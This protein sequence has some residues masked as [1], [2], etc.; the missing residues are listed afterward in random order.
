VRMHT[1]IR[2]RAENKLPPKDGRSQV[3]QKNLRKSAAK[4]PFL[5]G[6]RGSKSD[7]PLESNAFTSEGFPGSKSPFAKTEQCVRVEKGNINK[8]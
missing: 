4:K 2:N 3:H 1:I 8:K 7:E 6:K 5:V